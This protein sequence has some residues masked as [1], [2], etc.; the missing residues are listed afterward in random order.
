MRIGRLSDIAGIKDYK[1]SVILKAIVQ[2]VDGQLSFGDNIQG[3]IMRNIV[4]NANLDTPIVHELGRITNDFIVIGVN[5][6]AR[7]KRGSIGPTQDRIYLMCDSNVI[8]DI[9]VL[10]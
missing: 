10:G 4:F 6:Y 1:I 3:K 8:A 2:V 7:F 9:L 5:D